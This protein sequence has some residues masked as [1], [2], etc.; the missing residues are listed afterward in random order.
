MTM[1]H[2]QTIRSSP[3]QHGNAAGRGLLL[4]LWRRL[5][6]MVPTLDYLPRRD[7]VLYRDCVLPHPRLRRTM[8]GDDYTSNRFFVESGR[9]EAMRLVQKLGYTDK[10]NVVDI[11][12]GLGRLATGLLREVGDVQYWGFDAV[13]SW[14]LWCQEHIEAHH[15]SFRFQHVDVAN[16]LYNP[17]G[18]SLGKDFRFPLPDRHADIVY[19]WG[20]FTNMRLHDA[21][22]YVA[23]ISRL[24]R[25]GGRAFLTA[26]V[27]PNV[28]EESINPTGY[29][30][31]E[32]KVPLHVVRYD[33]DVLFSLFSDHGLSVE[34]FAYHGG[35]HCQQSEL[36]LRKTAKG[37]A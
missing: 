21:R 13:R 10:S 27:E 32:C 16:E 22:I 15:P 4:R 31:Y 2:D 7:Y 14:I 24:L 35:M 25:D 29:V 18:T 20:V 33:K 26:F 17:Q 9:A 34:E 28:P 36:H 6:R 19:M 8:C 5:Y 3:P 12:S 37:A 23:E 11:G 1:T 30:D